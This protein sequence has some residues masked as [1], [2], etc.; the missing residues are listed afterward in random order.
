ML[1]TLGAA[2]VLATLGAGLVTDPLLG[3]SATAACLALLVLPLVRSGFVTWI[4]VCLLTLSVAD[5]ALPN[6]ARLALSASLVLVAALALSELPSRGPSATGRAQV[7]SLCVFF[8]WMLESA[9]S[10]VPDLAVGVAGL[11]KSI[12]LFVGLWLG[13]VLARRLGSR[14]VLTLMTWLLAGSLVVALF[15]H[16][17]APGVEQGIVRSAG[18]ATGNFGGVYRLAGIFAGPFHAALASAALVVIA[19]ADFVSG[20][21][22]RLPTTV[23]LAVGSLALLQTDV[24]SGFVGLAAAVLYVLVLNPRRGERRV[25]RTLTSAGGFVLGALVAFRLSSA[26]G[27]LATTSSDVRFQGRFDIYAE[28]LRLMRDRPLL[29]YGSGSAGDTLNE[30]FFGRVHITAHDMLLK[31]AIEGGVIGLVLV[32]ALLVSIWLG[33]HKAGTREALVARGLLV[34]LLVMGVTGSVVEALPVSFWLPVVMGACLVPAQRGTKSIL[35]PVKFRT[36]ST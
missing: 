1:A 23:L 5:A 18:A 22:A 17:V 7:L 15:V 27:S 6:V 19:V 9:N 14:A 13:I 24:R 28:G 25:L 10:N 8:W 20:K 12:F 4:A 26:V 31:Y 35:V 30:E 21:R 16:N 3:L 34:L 33:L 32:C 36:R 2:L 29:G 11:R